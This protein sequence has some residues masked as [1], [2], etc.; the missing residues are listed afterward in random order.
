[1]ILLYDIMILLIS[2]CVYPVICLSDN[3]LLF[4]KFYTAYCIK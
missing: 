1:M 2:I 3:N 4:I